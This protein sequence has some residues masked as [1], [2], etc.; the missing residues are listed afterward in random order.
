[1]SELTIR[2][3]IITEK[4]RRPLAGLR[5]EAWTAD[6]GGQ[7][8]DAAV[9]DASGHFKLTLDERAQKLLAE[10]WQQVSFRVF[11]GEEAV[12]APVSLPVWHVERPNRPV[13]LALPDAE[14]LGAEALRG[15]F[16][17]GGM[18]TD[19]RGVAVPGAR[20]EVVDQ[21]IDGE[22]VL[23]EGVTDERGRYEVA[24]D[25]AALEDKALADLVVRVAEAGDERPTLAR[26]EV[27]YGAGARETIDVR[28]SSSDVAK[29]AEHERLLD[30][31]APHLGGDD[32][33]ELSADAVTRLAHKSG[34]DA[35]AV[36]MAARAARLARDTELPAAHYYA[37]FRSGVGGDRE[38]VQRLT[39]RAVESVLGDAVEKGVITADDSIEATVEGHRRLARGALAGIRTGNAMS[40]FGEMLELSL[41]EADRERFYGVFLE[42]GDRPQAFWQALDA[43]GFDNAT[44]ERLKTIAK[45]GKMSLQNRA[46]VGRILDHG[47]FEKPADLV[48][49]GLYDAGAWQELIGEDVPEDLT[50]ER[51]AEGLAAQVSLSYPALVTAELVRRDEIAVGGAEVKTE[52]V[53]FLAQGDGEQRIGVDRVKSW[54]GFEELSAEARS[55][56]LAV[57]RMYQMSPSNGA[58]ITLSNNGLSSAREIVS[59]SEEAFLA[60]MGSEFAS[61]R[62]AKLVYN[63]AQ[64]IHATALGVATG[65]L[66]QRSAPNVYVISGQLD[67]V[68][69]E[70]PAD[71]PGA[72][73]LEELF[74]NLDYCACEHCKSVLSPA[75]YMVELLQFLDPAGVTHEKRNPLAVLL[76]RRPD[77]EHILLSCENTNVVLPYIDIV[78]EIL[79]HYITNGNLDAFE[80]HNTSPEAVS[81]DLLADPQFVT[82]TAYDETVDKV[83]PWSLPFDMPLTAMRLLMKGLDLSLAELWGIFRGAAEA[84]REAL[85]LSVAEYSILT[86]LNH[87][88]LPEYFGEAPGLSIGQLNDAV[89]DGKT[90]SRRTAITHE[91]LVGLLGSGFINPGAALVPSLRRL[92][93]GLDTLQSWYDGGIADGALLGQLPSALDLA[94]FGGDVL[95]WLTNNRELIMGLI[96]LTDVSAEPVE[97]DFAQVEL[98]LALPDMTA[99]ALTELEYH[100]LLRFIRLWK[101]LGWSLE[102]TDDLILTFLDPAPAALT[103]AILDAAFIALLDRV[104]NFLRLAARLKLSRRKRAAWLGIW[105]PA[106]DPALRSE[107]LARL[108]RIGETDLESLIELSGID[109]LADDMNADEPSMLRFVELYRRL[110]GLGLKV[111][112]LD[113]LLRHQDADGDLTP[114]EEALLRDLKALRDALTAVDAQLAA[115]PESLDLAYVQTRMALVYDTPV[116]DWLLGLVA[117]STTYRA[118]FVMAEEVLPEKLVVVSQALGYDP[119]ARELT[120]T[121]VLSAGTH[122]ALDAAAD[123]LTLADVDQ[124]T[125][126]ADLDT[127]I[128][129]FKTATQALFDAG[130][131]DLQELDAQY[132]ELK[133]AYD[134]ASALADP[135][136]QA[137]ALL[138]AILPDL[139]SQLKETALRA[140]LAKLL[141]VDAAL[142]DAVLATTAAH[143]NPAEGVL[144]DLLALET[145][146]AFDADG[147]HEILLDPPSQDDY[148]LYV[149]APPNTDVT[150]TV[151]GDV[152]IPATTVGPAGEVRTAAPVPLG[153]GVPLAAEL[154]LA[155]LPGG[156]SAAL[157]WRTRGIARQPVPA[158]RLYDAARV[159]D[160]RASLLRLQKVT[161]LGELFG[162]TPRELVYFA[163]D[164]PA[165]AGFTNELAVAAGPPVAALWGKVAWLVWFLE[166]RRAAEPD[167]NAF[168]RIL[169]Q[170]DLATPQG[171]PLVAQANDW[172]PE[173]LTAVLAAFGLALTDLSSLP[174]LRRVVEAMRMLSEARYPGADIVAWAGAAPDAALFAGAKDSLR[175]RLDE[176]PWRELLQEVND[177]L[178]NQRL[179][180]LVAY[181][182]HH[183][184][185]AAGIDTAERLYEHFLVDVQMDACRR[186]SRIRQALS[187]I[188][189]FITRCLMNLE[190]E[191]AAASINEQHWQWMK[192]YRVWEANRKVFLYPENWLEPELRDGKSP[193]FRELEAELLKSDLTLELAEDAYH[194]YLKKLDDVARLEIVGTYLEERDPGDSRDDILHVIGR[195]NGSSREYYYR[196]LEYGYWTPWEKIPLSIE[197]PLAVPVVWKTRLFL[198]WVSIV[199]KTEA[200][201]EASKPEE[202][203]AEP[204]GDS[205]NKQVEVTFGW[206]EYFKGKWRSPKS[207]EGLSTIVIKTG[208]YFNP[209]LLE[210]YVRTYRPPA[211]ATERLLVGLAYWPANHRST[212]TFTSKNSPPIVTDAWDESLNFGLQKFNDDLFSTTSLYWWKWNNAFP[213]RMLELAVRVAQPPLATQAQR[214]QLLLNLNGRIHQAQ[215]D[216]VR[217]L[218]HLIKN[219]WEAPFFFSDRQGVFLVQ[220]DED[221]SVDLKVVYPIYYLPDLEYEYLVP[222]LEEIPEIPDDPLG[223]W[224]NEGYGVLHEM[225]PGLRTVLTTTPVFEYGGQRFAG[226]VMADVQRRR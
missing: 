204:W 158:S 92:G 218:W 109:P 152:L 104:G 178:R 41:A 200:G 32:L 56:A 199:E 62:E 68:R 91:E 37:L 173:I 214:T 161:M 2:G 142:V 25:P 212:L 162:L 128:A 138:D 65:Y 29:P 39:T 66:T 150:L 70:I 209:A 136:A 34:W 8:L 210:M 51:Y 69:K 17:V 15:G 198:F 26:S 175:E 181:I 72:P 93:L 13:I 190:Q 114:G 9:S 10:R 116:V 157:N 133:A 132:P 107:R 16:A 31:I 189:L 201:N 124:I 172:R 220:G 194:D 195:T 14:A 166:W 101:K 208:R 206:G 95:Q 141:G 145:A 215:M 111:T 53:D 64:E 167:E 30:A 143:G 121:G 115:S 156:G 58:M 187:S 84:R 98:R 23:A 12:S 78:N 99:N 113:Y 20:I 43:E 74:T 18:V 226:G 216:W 224:I 27:R 221:L 118:P 22:R 135:E 144:S 203:G 97:C 108:L 50:A 222:E 83:Y 196:R 57:E 163:D 54:Q 146:V 5:V 100:K 11:V 225:R 186:T 123:S 126:Q 6:Y 102:A 28:V 76:E 184:P 170:P 188:Q 125:A 105:D 79:E 137:T 96:T 87:K 129:D 165:T 3:Q 179:D 80:G 207:T 164:N 159:A 140:T 47:D 52:L 77:L 149:A 35:R 7:R 45:L 33:G 120:F 197:G 160:A 122:A 1:M 148:I 44:L 219:Q 82:E 177:E 130:A 48:R 86:D 112:D 119:F 202:L 59:Y 110:K 60:T 205:A 147:S 183:Q 67:R 151:G 61:S 106:A 176:R 134:T 85:G 46:L 139:R 63:K 42:H 155:N 81:A 24:Y 127:L 182:L 192:R 217:P 185:P 94:E 131:A 171:D 55:G 71:V 40:S 117:G 180:A 223:P 193:F 168:V 88:E 154:T 75:A 213:F 4:E 21:E 90:F 191:V 89:A 211:P 103:L 153:V 49:M 169:A 73:T 38:A 174:S 36:A 19:E